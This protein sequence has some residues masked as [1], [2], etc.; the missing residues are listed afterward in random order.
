MASAM[1]SGADTPAS[2]SAPNE[3]VIF[4]VKSIGVKLK[5][6]RMRLKWMVLRGKCTLSFTVGDK[7]DDQ[8]F[9]FR[10]ANNYLWELT[11]PFEILL[12]KPVMVSWEAESSSEPPIEIPLTYEEIAS[13]A[14]K[15]S[16]GVMS[17][18]TTAAVSRTAA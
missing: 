13:G 9:G 11:S 18:H 17:E 16:D 1:P 6:T 12:K 8:S 3:H 4:T 14:R 5:S 10:F 7:T 15:G 2:G